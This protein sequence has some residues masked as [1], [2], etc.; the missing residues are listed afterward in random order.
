MQ[1]NTADDQRHLLRRVKS[2]L[3]D[4]T[5][6]NYINDR[7]SSSQNPND[8]QE[9]R[10]AAVAPNNAQQMLRA[11]ATSNNATPRPAAI[12]PARRVAVVSPA[13]SV[14]AVASTSRGYPSEIPLIDLTHSA[15]S[16]EVS[17]SA[18]DSSITL[19]LP[20]LLI[21]RIL[22]WILHLYYKLQSLQQL[23]LTD[24]ADL[25]SSIWL[26][27]CILI[28]DISLFYVNTFCPLC[29]KEMYCLQ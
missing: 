10:V 11:A 13:S 14:A 28:G 26:K 22:H 1:A 16:S 5:K 18:R 7:A 4:I 24:I 17:S 12:G 20:E 27:T 2:W 9:L 15:E 29:R 8:G 19:E 25:S 21:P 6:L 23:S 3:D